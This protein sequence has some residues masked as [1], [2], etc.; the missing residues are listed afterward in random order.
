MVNPCRLIVFDVDEIIL[1]EEQVV[2]SIAQCFPVGL[3]AFGYGTNF[4]LGQPGCSSGIRKS[5]NVE[6]VSIIF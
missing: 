2:G 6:T 1:E 5:N 3:C 4:Q